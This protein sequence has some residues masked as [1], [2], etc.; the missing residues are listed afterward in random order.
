MSSLK[1]IKN[2]KGKYLPT[3]MEEQLR[4]PEEYVMGYSGSYYPTQP[5][6]ETSSL[7]S[8]TIPFN[9]LNFLDGLSLESV[10]DKLS[11][12]VDAPRER[13]LAIIRT[14]PQY[15]HQYAVWLGVEYGRY[16]GQYRACILVDRHHVLTIVKHKD[17]GLAILTSILKLNDG[18]GGCSVNPLE[19]ARAVHPE[20][21]ESLRRKGTIPLLFELP[22]LDNDR[23]NPLFFLAKPI[24]N[25]KHFWEE[26]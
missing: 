1:K 10:Y 3:F 19:L 13:P 7:A 2:F 24:L 21:L 15:C 26:P 5:R 18:L 6:V 16:A 4:S 20:Y 12:I 17:L 14:N 8:S 11:L 22:F 25:D 23:E 9:I